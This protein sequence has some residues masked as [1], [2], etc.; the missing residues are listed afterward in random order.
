MSWNEYMLVVSENRQSKFRL[1]DVPLCFP[2]SP[3][4]HWGFQWATSVRVKLFM[5]PRIVPVAPK[6]GHSVFYD[7]SL[8]SSV[9]NNSDKYPMPDPTRTLGPYHAEGIAII[10]LTST[11]CPRACLIATLLP[12]VNRDVNIRSRDIS[13]GSLYSRRC[14]WICEICRA[15]RK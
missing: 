7:S 13:S 5:R 4:H 6:K 12:M 8:D 10:M 15:M 2:A 9:L 3:V 14:R 1:Q 11:G